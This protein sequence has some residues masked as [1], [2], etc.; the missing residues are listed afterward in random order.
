MGINSFIR[1]SHP[2]SD[3]APFLFLH[4]RLGGHLAMSGVILGSAG[5]GAGGGLSATIQNLMSR[6]EGSKHPKMHMTAFPQQRM[7]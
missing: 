1:A 5:L 6:D 3:A 4:L 2:S 7:F